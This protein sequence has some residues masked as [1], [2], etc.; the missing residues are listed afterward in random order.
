[1]MSKVK[2]G[3]INYKK[4]RSKKMMQLYSMLLLPV[5]FVFVFSYGSMAGIIMAFQDFLPGQG[6]YVFGSQFVGLK[7][8]ERLFASPEVFLVLRNTVIISFLKIVFGTVV[9]ITIAVLMNEIFKTWFK[10]GVQTVIFLPHFI[11]W[12]ILSGVFITMFDKTS[13]VMTRV[14]GSAGITL[15]DFF[16]DPKAFPFMLI[17]SSLWKDAGYASIVYIA[18]ITTIDGSLYE[19]AKIDGAGHIKRCFHI[20][21]PGMMPVIIM[22]TVLNMGNV[23]NAGFEQVFNMYNLD[24]YETG[25]ILETFVYRRAFSGA[26]DYSFSTAVGLLKSVISLIFIS[27]SYFIADK[28]FDYKIF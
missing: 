12:V 3:E 27:V 18:A 14:F 7:H 28:L 4:H 21:L 1:M 17:A 11:S 6:F 22:M 19:A 8:F 23:L 20:T 2:T 13:G 5:L 15:P 24:V 9:P 25:D 26:P 16:H 10:R